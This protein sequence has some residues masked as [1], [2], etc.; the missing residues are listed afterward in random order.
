MALE[1]KEVDLVTFGATER[2]CFCVLRLDQAI[3]RRLLRHLTYV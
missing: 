2:D 3:A 1:A